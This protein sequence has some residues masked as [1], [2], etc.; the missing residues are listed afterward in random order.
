FNNICSIGIK[1][2]EFCQ[3]TQ[4][5]KHAAGWRLQL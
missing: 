2:L 4:V 5:Y 3:C 1:C